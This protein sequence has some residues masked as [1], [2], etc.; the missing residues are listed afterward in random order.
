MNTAIMNMQ[1]SF[2]RMDSENIQESVDDLVKKL[3]A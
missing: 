1:E 2:K 3:E